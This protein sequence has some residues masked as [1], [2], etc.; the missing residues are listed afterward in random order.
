MSSTNETIG[1]H[2][3]NACLSAP[4]RFII[5]TVTVICM[6]YTAHA[7]VKGCPD[8]A[9]NNYSNAATV[10]DG[11]C[12]YND[13]AVKP[14]LNTNLALKLNETSGLIWWNNQVW[15][16]ND[17][18]GE[19]ALYAV[20]TATGSIRK[21]VTV[22]NA[23][24][25]DWEDIAQDD[26]FI[27]IGDFGNNAN[28]NRQDLKIYKV[29]KVDVQSKTSVKATVINFSYSDQTDF[30]PTGSNNT[31]FNCEAMIAYGDSLFLFSKDWVDNKTRIYKLPKVAGTYKAIN[32]GEWN[33]EG[34]ITGADIIPDK[35]VIVLSG[36]NA[37]V[38]PFVFLLYDFTGNSFFGANKRKVDV[39]QSFLQIEGI[40]P[41]TSTSFLISNE[42]L[43]TVVTTKAKLQTLDLNTLLNPYYT[44]L[45]A[46][47]AP[48]VR[49]TAL[50][51]YSTNASCI[52]AIVK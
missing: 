41:V 18:G 33:V 28:G 44:T 23:T 8:P 39:S 19:P 22:S 4:F 14:R 26:A 47:Q 27:Y 6:C 1:S 46:R 21:K 36:Y 50:P 25:V 12:T 52:P 5:V 37:V 38:T 20:D 40:C 45:S 17:S 7:Q 29:K 35:R 48:I 42:R 34:L 2:G 31:N 24:N 10:N 15:T 51:A 13:V 11:S 9:A 49:Y 32:I 43:Q 16:H 3:S 30:S